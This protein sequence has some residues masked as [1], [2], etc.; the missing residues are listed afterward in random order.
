[1]E[2]IKVSVDNFVRAES[3]RML[4]DLAAAAGGVNRWSHNR[5]PAAVDDQVVV[6][7]NRDT[8]YS[9]AVVDLAE[10]AL[11][12]VPDAGQRYL[13]VMV[14][15]QDHF[16][17]HIL[18]D[19]GEYRVEADDVGTRYAL[20]ATRILVDPADRFDV[21]TVTALQDQLDVRASSAKPFV[22]PHYDPESFDGV[23]A[24]LKELARYSTTSAGTFGGPD[25]VQPV[26]HLIGAA[27]GW[28]GLPE[29][30][31]V[32]VNV[33]PGLA[34]GR[35]RLTVGEVPVDGFWS[36]TVY[37]AAGFLVPNDLDAYAINDITAE[38]DPDGSISIHLGPADEADDLP[39]YLPIVEG[40]NY[41][42]RLYRP[43]REI[44]DGSW[45]F[46]QVDPVG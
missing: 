45:S 10:G 9:F 14:V 29:R 1:V 13:S 33:D 4:A 36:V 15:S 20:F 24:A 38:R 8:L 32:Y 25:E 41:L 23:R 17:T 18:H 5:A 3:D 43:R 39:N 6:R 35:Y 12:R 28:G 42:V 22:L 46:P 34:V 26:H 31:A 40:W 27:A 7:L 44:L 2:L 21:A 37:D 11:L 16:V 19:A 30:E